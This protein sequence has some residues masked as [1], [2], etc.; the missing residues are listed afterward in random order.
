MLI[1]IESA[2]LCVLFTLAVGLVSLKD[3]LAGIHNWPS[4]IQRR[5]R[6]LGLIQAEQMAGS[7]K[8]CAKKLAG[9]LTALPAAML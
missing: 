5:A 9:G 6:E 4:A 3:P 8:T 7:K 1:L 2:A